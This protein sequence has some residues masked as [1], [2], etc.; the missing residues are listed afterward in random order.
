M[1]LFN[2]ESDDERTQMLL[3]TSERLRTDVN[4]QALPNWSLEDTCDA[5]SA[6]FPLAGQP[7]WTVAAEVWAQ[8]AGQANVF[9][10]QDHVATLLLQHMHNDPAVVEGTHYMGSLQLKNNGQVRLNKG[11]K[12]IRITLEGLILIP[13]MVFQGTPILGPFL[14][15]LGVG[16]RVCAQVMGEYKARWLRLQER[17]T[18]RSDE[19]ISNNQA[20]AQVGGITEAQ[21]NT[22]L[23]GHTAKAY[24][25]LYFLGMS[26]R[27]SMVDVGIEPPEGLNRSV[28][29]HT[30]LSE[31]GCTMEAARASMLKQAVLTRRAEVDAEAT[32]DGKKRRMHTIVDEQ[33]RELQANEFGRIVG[34]NATEGRAAYLRSARFLTLAPQIGPN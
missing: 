30:Q 33:A 4:V 29:A 21:A 1:A 22:M 11:N 28:R 19:Y 12:N 2:P 6:F 5:V 18:R 10:D 31:H 17:R 9:T 20:F 16:I 32:P 27:Q 24:K 26:M 15:N 3:D 25:N 7:V 34:A 8:T 13:A 23:M 14:N